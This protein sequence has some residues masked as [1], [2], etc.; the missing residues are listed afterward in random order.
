MNIDLI[1]RA[2]RIKK[3]RYLYN[4]IENQ[5]EIVERLRAIQRIALDATRTVGMIGFYENGFNEVKAY[6]SIDVYR[7]VL[8]LA[9]ADAER[10]LGKLLDEF[11]GSVK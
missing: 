5:S 3:A 11:E 2:E 4:K 10:D 8:D 1:E 7:A 9:L 6:F